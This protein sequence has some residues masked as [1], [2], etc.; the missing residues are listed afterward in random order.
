M[1]AVVVSALGMALT[2]AACAGRGPAPAAPEPRA[3]GPR[4]F[5]FAWPFAEGSALAPRG[6]TTKGSDVTL[7]TEPGDAW[8]ALQAPGLTDFE[9]D[10]RA[11]LAMAG[12]FRTSFDFIEVAGF[13]P[14]WAPDRPYQSWAT[15]RV[16]VL[17]DRGRFVSLQH[18]L[19]M[20]FVG[21]DGT[22]EGPVVTK[23]WRQ[24]W[25]YED[26]EMLVYRGE[27][28]WETIPVPSHSRRGSWTQA[29]FQVDDSPRYESHGRWRH[30]G[31]YHAWES[32]ETWRP[33]P[34][35][36]FSVRQ[37]YQVLVGTNRHAITP[38]GW[39]QEEDNLK[40]A[41]DGPGRPAA[42]DPVIARELGVNRYER[43]ADFDASAA[44][45]YWER[46]APLWAAVRA[47]WA[48]TIDDHPV[49]RL[50]GAPDRD[51]LFT[52]LFE[53]AERLEEGETQT[54]EALAALARERVR[55][56]LRT[57]GESGG[58]GGY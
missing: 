48:E 16:L 38:T 29:V 19:V 39:V 21:R 18:V 23:H 10:R 31:N 8:R 2:L 45:R 37:D 9:R 40:V 27:N 14:G 35:R 26:T 25:T 3:A 24:D 34:R 17:E 1:R 49:L 57:P 11:I 32:A 44:E 7:D 58:A 43:V 12:T 20:R 51:Q 13:R 4:Q 28:T 5:T 41:L 46:T 52:P 6:G 36:E 54:P 15:E 55:A 53:D 47:A 50:T 56:Y 22:V 33:L 42:T 30:L